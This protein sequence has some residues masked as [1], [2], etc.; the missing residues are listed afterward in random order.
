M[1][2]AV[3]G[4]MMSSFIT[5]T[6][7]Y[8]GARYFGDNS[9]TLLDS[10]VF[11]SLISSIDPVAILSVLT[12]LK[13]SETDTIYIL[14]FGESLLNDGIAITLFKSLV[15]QYETLSMSLDDILGAVA[16]FF[17]IAAGSCSIGFAC[18]V[19][20]L[21]YFHLN[22]SILDPVMEVAS[23]FLWAV[24]P[25]W[26]SEALGWSGIVAIVVM[27]FF[28]DIYL[29][30]GNIAPVFSFPANSTLTFHKGWDPAE[31]ELE[32]DRRRL[33]IEQEELRYQG[34]D[35]DLLHDGYYNWEDEQGFRF[36]GTAVDIPLPRQHQAPT[37]RPGDQDEDN[38]LTTKQNNTKR[39]D[40]TDTIA[41]TSMTTNPNIKAI[42]L[43]REFVR[44]SR[45]ADE[46][47]RFVAHI[48]SSMSENAIFAYL[49]LFLFS[50]QYKW[51]GILCSIGVTSCVISRALMVICASKFIWFMHIFRQ[52]AGCTSA[53]QIHEFRD[54]EADELSEEDIDPMNTPV[55][56]SARA[57]SNY[58]VQVGAGVDFELPINSLTFECRNPQLP[59]R[60]DFGWSERCSV[61][62]PRR[63]CPYL[64]RSN[65]YWHQE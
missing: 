55:S 7:T 2:F 36:R 22:S 10:L 43:K 39:D 45:E 33:M 11:G 31:L 54:D 18:G 29:R 62:C 53:N 4:T 57:L 46:H 24:V 61:P 25:Y 15:Q 1:V 12:S 51:D 65:G 30:P 3:F 28:M 6:A 37:P 13:M 32:E 47:V 34:N 50:S 21:F 5:G 59:G 58:K 64:Q 23:F 40:D 60:V 48:L 19:A 63:D 20:C 14:V 16:D 17:I 8:Y 42:L 27:G 38:G 41:G 9:L 26:L 44:M 56:K 52:R 49:G 35:S